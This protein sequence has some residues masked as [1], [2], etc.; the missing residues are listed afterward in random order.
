MTESE[1]KQNIDDYIYGN[2]SQSEIDQLFIVF[3]KAPEWFEYYE[4]RE[5]FLS[6]KG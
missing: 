1:I 4:K 5:R 3:L 6:L 2:L